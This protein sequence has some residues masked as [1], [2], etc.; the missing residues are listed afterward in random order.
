MTRARAARGGA[1][2]EVKVDASGRC[3]S[4][5]LRSPQDGPSLRTAMSNVSDTKLYDIL[6]VSPSASEN[7][8]KK[9]GVR[10]SAL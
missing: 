7:E 8:L 6:G 2:G 3:L 9:V 10:V 1:W 4:S 5:A